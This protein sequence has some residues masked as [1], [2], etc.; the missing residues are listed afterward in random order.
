MVNVAPPKPTRILPESERNELLNHDTSPCTPVTHNHLESTVPV[1][2]LPVDHN[3]G[4]MH[5]QD[6]SHF[7][8]HAWDA[9]TE[10]LL[11]SL[12]RQHLFPGL[13]E[14]PSSM[15]D[16]D[17][18]WVQAPLAT[19][20]VLSAASSMSALS[21]T[22]SVSKGDHKSESMSARLEA[23]KQSPD[24]QSRSTSS[25]QDSVG[26]VQ[27]TLSEMDSVKVDKFH[28][29]KSVGDLLQKD[30]DHHLEPVLDISKG[31]M[32]NLLP[33]TD[34]EPDIIESA[35]DKKLIPN[36]SIT[37]DPTVHRIG[38]SPEFGTK[39]TLSND[40]DTDNTDMLNDH[41]ITFQTC[42]V[43][44]ETDVKE[45]VYERHSPVETTQFGYANPNEM[46]SPASIGYIPN[47]S[48]E[49]CNHIEAQNPAAIKH[50]P[51]SPDKRL[52]YSQS[53][54]RLKGLSDQFKM[55]RSTEEGD[56]AHL[57]DSSK[58]F[59]GERF[60][61][62]LKQRESEP[63]FDKKL[64]PKIERR[65]ESVEEIQSGTQDEQN[66]VDSPKTDIVEDEQEQNQEQLRKGLEI[67]VDIS[68]VES[69]V[70]DIDRE[71]VNDKI[72]LLS[73]EAFP[74]ED[75]VSR[76]RLNSKNSL[77][78]TRSSP[79]RTPEEEDMRLFHSQSCH[80]TFT[81]SVSD[82]SEQRLSLI[83]ANSEELPIV[84]TDV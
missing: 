64:L 32:A 25:A 65:L 23:I 83:S 3:A 67:C 2:R 54:S 61:K 4:E 82:G 6:S 79:G 60:Q 71:V 57:M 77:G 1:V 14:N 49:L 51:R 12:D 68:N 78:S 17:S 35:T 84:E 44:D 9:A 47:H 76:S 11:L 50:S 48:S 41:P 37:F 7:N 80:S 26:D 70:S 42:T 53:E 73:D 21:R 24:M 36:R 34:Y 38:S 43:V 19:P 58:V 27:E 8:N 30:N 28:E 22:C 29:C 13:F 56:I 31:S 69:D 75:E 59:V 20:E 15:I 45:S 46:Y 18:E 40:T 72:C 10:E 66:S 63:V 16:L 5:E 33:N 39:R 55:K 62:V 52:H 74:T 81:S